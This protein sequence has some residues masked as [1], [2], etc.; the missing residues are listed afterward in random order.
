MFT[1]AGLVALVILLVLSAFWSGA[2]TALTSLSKYRVKKLIA[3][4]KSISALLGQWLKSPYYL[5]TTILVGNTTND[6]L[7]SSIVAHWDEGRSQIEATIKT[8]NSKGDRFSFDND[9]V[10]RSC[11][12]L[13]DLPIRFKVNSFKQDNIETIKTNWPEIKKSL[14]SMVDM[15][16]EWG[17]CGDTLPTFN[18]VIPIAYFIFKGGDVANSKHVLQQ[19]LVRALL[20]Q[21]F[22]S[23]TD[24]V[25]GAIRDHLR[26]AKVNGQQTT[27]SLNFPTLKLADV[28][29]T[30]LPDVRTLIVTDADIEE[31]LAEGKGP[32]TFM[33]LSLLYPQLKFDQVKFHQDHIHPWSRFKTADLKKLGLSDEKVSQWQ[34]D[35][36]RLPNLQLMEGATNQSKN[37][38]AFEDWIQTLGAAKDHFTKTNYIPDTVSLNLVYFEAFFAARKDLLRAKMKAVLTQ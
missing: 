22:A 25:L 7:F 31:L 5:L 6:L 38:T 19:Y 33:V 9:F 24:R 12:V 29:A 11:L 14:E 2:E 23:K 1:F 16:V 28:I 15:L 35:R 20:N 18:A 13:S 37:A 36:D 17:F 27:Y 32:Y 4:N 30:K 34:E 8:L 3:V 21:I 26:T 10:M